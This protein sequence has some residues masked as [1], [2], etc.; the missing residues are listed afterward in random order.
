MS[1]IEEATAFM[2]I[3]S[4]TFGMI[5]AGVCW[6]SRLVSW[7]PSH[8]IF[9]SALAGGLAGAG[10]GLTLAG[11]GFF[12]SQVQQF[13]KVQRI[14]SATMRYFLKQTLVFSIPFFTATLFTKPLALLLGR[15]VSIKTVASY[16]AFNA[17][18][19]L[20]SYNLL[21]S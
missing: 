5:N 19:S 16:G 20:Y 9:E 4:L 11:L 10:H 17:M 2:S 15:E 7:I 8:S 12:A 3:S 14:Q 21:K 1:A 18:L 13:W 6:G